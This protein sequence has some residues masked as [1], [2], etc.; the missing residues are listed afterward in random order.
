[1]V[2]ESA[3][4]TVI[5]RAGGNELT[6]LHKNIK[7]LVSSQTSLMPEYEQALSPEDCADLIS[8]IKESLT[9]R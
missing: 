9:I 1:M 4:S 8:W 2:N 6:F 3:N 5:R 7:S